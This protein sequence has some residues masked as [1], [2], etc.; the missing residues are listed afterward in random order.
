VAGI[1]FYT[2]DKF[3]KWKG[4]LLVTSLAHQKFIRLEIGGRAVKRQEIVFQR[5]GRLR[6]VRCFDDGYVY[7]IFD[8]PE[9]IARLVPAG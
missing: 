8:Q 3:P 6:D 4:N 1:D 7:L 5:A 9:K 2:G